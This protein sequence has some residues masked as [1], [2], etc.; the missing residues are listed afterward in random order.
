MNAAAGAMH[1]VVSLNICQ[2]I[3][4]IE[5][6]LFCFLSYNETDISICS[7]VGPEII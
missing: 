6:E 3:L 7:I 5:G 2:P 1:K 4:E